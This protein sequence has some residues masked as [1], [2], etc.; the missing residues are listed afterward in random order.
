MTLR[1]GTRV[2]Q[3]TYGHGEIVVAT[4]QHV[5]VAFDDG[6]VRKFVAAIVALEPS[7]VP[8]PP[9]VAPPRATRSAGRR[10]AQGPAK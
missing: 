3:A 1:E 2:R 4:A 10:G 8:R 6:S 7:E 9:K 5:T